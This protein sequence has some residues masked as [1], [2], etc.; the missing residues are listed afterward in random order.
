MAQLTAD[1]MDD[2]FEKKDHE[3]A[4]AWLLRTNTLMQTL[5]DNGSRVASYEIVERVISFSV[6]DGH[7]HY[8]VVTENPL[9]LRHLPHGEAYQIGTRRMEALTAADVHAMVAGEV[10]LSGATSNDAHLRVA[11]SVW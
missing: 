8:L 3:S 7:A 5:R 4:I 9:R 11:E 6:A 1:V 2:R 10:C